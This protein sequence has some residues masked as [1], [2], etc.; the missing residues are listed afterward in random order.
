MTTQDVIHEMITENTGS[1]MLDSGGAY[2]RNWQRN[3]EKSIE[4][5]AAEPQVSFD[6]ITDY[7]KESTDIC[8][9]VSLWHYLTGDHDGAAQLMIDDICREFNKVNTTADNWDSDLM[10]GLS[11]EGAEYLQNFDAS[12]GDAWNTYNGENTLSQV[13]QGANVEIDGDEYVL[14]QIHGGCDVRGGYTDARLFKFDTAYQEG[15]INP[16][17]CVLGDIDGKQVDSCYNGYSLTDE[18][19]EALPITVK[20]KVSLYLN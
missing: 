16:T 19:G 10:Y 12:I 14:F 5:F 8:Y 15:Y 4:A 6:E 13:L 1:H 2:G 20:S 9:T 18:S 17:P 11:S 7:E 3:K